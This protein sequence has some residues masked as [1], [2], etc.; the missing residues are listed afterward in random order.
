[1]ASPP[2]TERQKTGSD[3]DKSVTPEA[4]PNL[5][6]ARDLARQIGQPHG[7]VDCFLRRF[8]EKHPDCRVGTDSPRKNEAHY[9]YRVAD[10]WPALEERLKKWRS[11]PGN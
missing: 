2:I 4:L 6:S 3:A 8:H 5:L 11:L 1:M 7:L 9:L 10:V